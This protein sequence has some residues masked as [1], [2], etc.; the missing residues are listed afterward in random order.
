L[1]F[2][3]I[4]VKT[5][6][7]YYQDDIITRTIR[8]LL[9]MVMGTWNVFIV[10]HTI[11]KIYQL[12]IKLKLFRKTKVVVKIKNTTLTPLD[13]DDLLM[14]ISLFLNNFRGYNPLSLEWIRHCLNYYSKSIICW[15]KI[16]QNHS[17]P[18]TWI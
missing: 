18:V 15:Q 4:N 3:I 17:E 2:F 16:R 5:S 13:N 14:K 10:F 7:Q 1:K 6:Q 12:I 8:F 11:I 9:I